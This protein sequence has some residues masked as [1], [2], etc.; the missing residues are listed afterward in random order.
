MA[1]ELYLPTLDPKEGL[2][3]DEIL[4]VTANVP[5]ES[6]KVLWVHYLPY[7]ECSHVHEPEYGFWDGMR[8]SAF[9]YNYFAH[10]NNLDFY[11][12]YSDI[13]RSIF[14]YFD[15][16]AIKIIK[17][18]IPVGYN[19]KIMRGKYSWLNTLL[20][21]LDERTSKDY[22]ER[23]EAKTRALLMRRQSK[24]EKYQ[25]QINQVRAEIRETPSE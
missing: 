8:D 23:I 12:A 9:P 22:N 7:E 3:I 21:N 5:L 18:G 19:E 1:K 10:H 20:D 16:I 11:L 4:K 24:R 15:K 17:E 2:L 13:S 14:P 25:Q 6:W